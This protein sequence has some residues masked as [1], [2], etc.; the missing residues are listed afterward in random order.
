MTVTPATVAAGTPWPTEGQLRAILG[1][2]GYEQYQNYSEV[3][4]SY[5]FAD[6]LATPVNLAGEP[7]SVGQID[8]LA[9]IV[10]ENS[11]ADRGRPDPGEDSATFADALAS[12]DWDNVMAQTKAILSPTQWRAAQGPLL[13]AQLLAAVAQDRKL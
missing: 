1:D 2:L 9:Q 5:Q 4:Y 10:A 3:R 13:N 12:V 11:A 6:L 8:Q 7:L